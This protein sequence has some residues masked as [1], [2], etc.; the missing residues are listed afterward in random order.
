MNVLLVSD[1]HLTS[2]PRDEYRWKLFPW[3]EKQIR[4]HEVD[5]L[6]ILGDLTESRDYHAAKLVNRVVD[7]LCGL[8]HENEGLDHIF[9]LRGN[10]DG[11]DPACPYF[12]FLGTLPF[13]TYIGAP[14]LRPIEKA[15]ILFLPHSRNPETEWTTPE[16]QAWLAKADAIF[17][18]QTVA[19]AQSENG[20]TL[21]GISANLLTAAKAKSIWSGDIHVPQRI[22]RVN[23][24]GSPYPIRFGD[25]FKPRAVLLTDD[26]SKAQD[27]ETPRFGRHRIV[28]DPGR[29]DVGVLSIVDELHNHSSPNDQVKVRVR[30]T[31]VQFV[32]WEKIKREVVEACV[33]AQVELCGIEVERIEE[34]PKIRRR[35][36]GSAAPA[37]TPQ[38]ILEGWCQRQGVEK[39]LA[40]AGHKLLTEAIR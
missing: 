23:Y 17:M 15:R 24:I 6:F 5:Y 21:E 18:H 27:L 1:L 20:T 25:S 2:S 9:L 19:G 38:Q 36:Q 10:H 12:R 29:L 3:L 14:I 32:E 26:L 33:K 34:Q 11:T 35:G 8:P 40:E 16:V 31:R 30:L 22:G 4:V 28:L 13:L 37:L 7:S 39:S